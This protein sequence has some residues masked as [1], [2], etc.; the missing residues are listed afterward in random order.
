MNSLFRID[1][2]LFALWFLGMLL[3]IAAFRLDRKER[4]NR[5]FYAFGRDCVRPIGVRVSHVFDEWRAGRRASHHLHR[6][7]HRP[8]L[9]APSLTYYWFRLVHELTISEPV[10]TNLRRLWMVGIVI[11]Y[12]DCSYQS[13]S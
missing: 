4:L 8:F 7:A 3:F 11:N 13:D 12:R 2:N 5:L 10:P 6:I 9:T 1:V